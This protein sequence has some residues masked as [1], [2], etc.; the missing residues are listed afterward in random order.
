MA[1]PY[2]IEYARELDRK[3]PLSSFRQ[4]FV[5]E[6]PA[7][8]YLDG[9]SLGRLPKKTVDHLGDTIGEQW[10]RKL[11]GSWND[12]WY[13]LST[14]LGKKIAG[15]LGA[16]PDE[17]IVS[18]STSIN[19][20][21]LAFGA[22]RA[23]EGR[24]G[25]IS[26]ELNFPT[27][28]YILQGLIKQLGGV[29]KLRLLKSRDGISPELA[30]LERMIHSGTALLCL[31]HVAFKS[32]YMYDMERVTSLAHEHGVLVLWD[33][34]HSAGVVPVDLNGAGVDLAVGCTYKYLNG[35]PGSPAFLYVR[36]E[37]QEQL[38]NPV[39]GWFGEQNPF[40]FS[41]QYQASEGIRKFLTG[42]PP[43][44]S[45]SALEPALDMVLE[46][47]IGP[48]R[49][50]SENQSE[51]LLTHARHWLLP[52]EVQIGSPELIDRRGS[53]ISLIHHEGYRICKALSDPELGE[54]PVIP[55]FREPDNIRLGISPLYTSFEDIFRAMTQLRE[56]ISKKLYESYSQT[57][58]QVT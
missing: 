31:S 20:Y 26:D 24:S 37:L 28:L 34:S 39:Q 35:G 33:L 55:D 4:A 49:R 44:L 47:G 43:V 57:R 46:A 16:S 8:I 22:L 15:I 21:K 1:K 9:N 52:K 5:R 14:R 13:D 42:T 19:L 10:G 38:E 51:Y 3:D 2:T 58:D 29:H 40:D 54:G 45:L 32:S 27:D 7:L 23:R 56:I 18:D 41:L 11:I 48:I 6:D 50:K 25:I 36:K 30:E 53:H 17:V 12:H